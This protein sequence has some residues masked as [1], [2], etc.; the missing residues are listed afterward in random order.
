MLHI[1][2]IWSWSQQKD[3]SHGELHASATTELPSAFA[4][5]LPLS[6]MGSHN[7]LDNLETEW[8]Y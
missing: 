1:D 5:M 2:S 3:S 8:C 7:S 6:F 4:N